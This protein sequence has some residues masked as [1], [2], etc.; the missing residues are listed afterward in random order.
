[1]EDGG[2]G[3]NGDWGVWIRPKLQQSA[4]VYR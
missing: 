3:N 1:V 4:K 2:D